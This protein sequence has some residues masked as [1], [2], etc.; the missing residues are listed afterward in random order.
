MISEYWRKMGKTEADKKEGKT[1]TASDGNL[2]CDECCNG[3]RCDEPSHYYR[4]N[5]PFCLGTGV[6]ASKVANE[7]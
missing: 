2:R 4:P 5:C 6:N 1:W 7:R 3:D